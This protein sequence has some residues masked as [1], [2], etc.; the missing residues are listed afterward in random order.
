MKHSEKKEKDQQAETAQ[1]PVLDAAP[2]E[3]GKDMEK[4]E[5]SLKELEEKAKE[6]H[7]KYLLAVADL[8]NYRKRA[9]R[10]KIAAVDDAQLSFIRGLLPVVDNIERALGQLSAHEEAKDVRE[11]LQ[12]IVKQVHAYLD[13]V[14]LKPFSSVCETFDPHK[15]EA[16]LHVPSKDHPDHSVVEEVQKGYSWHGRIV[17]HALVKVA[18]NPQSQE[19]KKE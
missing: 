15:H 2:V 12:L 19:H 10:E 14:G 1:E 8:D 11:G 9:Q 13:A 5:Q 17:R 3:P 4:L 18:D 6:T 7:D 16:I